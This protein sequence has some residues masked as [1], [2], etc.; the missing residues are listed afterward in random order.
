MFR[1]EFQT[2]GVEFVQSILH[3]MRF[4]VEKPFVSVFDHALEKS[5]Q[6]HCP[7]AGGHG[8]EP[9]VRGPDQLP[10]RLRAAVVFGPGVVSGDVLD[11]NQADVLLDPLV[12]AGI[13]LLS[14]GMQV[15]GTKCLAKRPTEQRPR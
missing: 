13:S 5:L 2:L 3:G 12:G 14:C 11:V 8:D 15:A 10:G 9:R 4:D 1:D 7:L 6:V